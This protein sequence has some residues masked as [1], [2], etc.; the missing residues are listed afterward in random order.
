MSKV[1]RYFQQAVKPALQ[2]KGPYRHA[3]LL[4]RGGR[5]LSVGCNSADCYKD[6]LGQCRNGRMHAEVNAIMNYLSSKH[7]LSLTSF[8]QKRYKGLREDIPQ[9]RYLCYPS[10]FQWLDLSLQTM[11]SLHT[12]AEKVRYQES[13]LQSE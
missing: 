11:L 1:Q 9:G 8:Y 7:H 10:S 6:S 2:V 5:V 13:V 12:V 4:V 3:A